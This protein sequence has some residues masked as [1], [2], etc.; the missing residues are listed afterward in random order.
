MARGVL[1]AMWVELMISVSSFVWGWT[2]LMAMLS[3]QVGLFAFRSLGF[4]VL[5]WL[6][7]LN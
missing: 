5:F 7:L 6:V 2:L 4:V 3:M 1:L